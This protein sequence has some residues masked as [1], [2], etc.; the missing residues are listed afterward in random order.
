M[1]RSLQPNKSQQVT[2]ARCEPWLLVCVKPL[3]LRP[4]PCCFP[5]NLETVDCRHHSKGKPGTRNKTP[6]LLWFWRHSLLLF[7]CST[8]VIYETI[9]VVR[10]WYDAW[11][12]IFT[13]KHPFEKE[14]PVATM[15]LCYS[16]ID[17]YP[18]FVPI[19]KCFTTF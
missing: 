3:N 10:E 6:K 14:K 13:L 18:L 17:L 2:C 12:G 1:C 19:K 7:H 4:F 8:T 15:R 9:P 5:G 11:P 16:N